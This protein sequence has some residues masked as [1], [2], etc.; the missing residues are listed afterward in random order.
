M[1]EC[2][3]V[4]ITDKL[5]RY[6]KVKKDNNTFT[7]DSYGL[8]FYSNLNET[9]EQ[10]IAETN[11]SNIPISSEVLNE[12]YY[13]FNIFSLTNKTYAE[14]AIKTEFES[15]CTE[16]HLNSNV[17]DGK[18]IYT[19]N[20]DN[21][22]QSRI[23]YIFD[24]QTDIAERRS[25]FD[26]NKVETLVPL[27]TTLPNLITAEKNKNSMIINIDEKTTIT[28]IVNQSIYNIDIL[29]DG[30]KDVLERINE[31]ENSY[32]K[33]YEVCKN[34]TIYTM[35]TD[36]S[37]V[38]DNEYLKYI[39]P[40][41]FKIQ[42]EVQRLKE[43][44]KKIDNIYITGMGAV[45]NN[46]DLYFK[47]YFKET[48]VEIL[49]PYFLNDQANVNIKDYIEVNSAIALA[50]QG[51][52]SGIKT[53]NFLAR[54][55]KSD[56]MT[57]LTS[58]VSTLRANKKQKTKAPKTKKKLNFN[59]KFDTNMKGQ[60][61]K[62]ETILLRNVVTAI[63]V[64]IIYSIASIV[65]AKQID[66]KTLEAKEVQS[67]TSEQIAAA[68]NDDSV[69]LG[70]TAD[71][72]TYTTNLENSSSALEQRRSRKN[73]LT[74]LLNK[75]VYNIP[76]EVTLTQINNTERTEG[77]NTIQHITMQAQARRYEQLAYFK[78]KLK[79]A[80]ILDNITSTEGQKDGSYVTITI[81][82]DLK[83]Y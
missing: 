46:I 47:E 56:L 81:E 26:G 13:Y 27:P 66:N 55:W 37:N 41:L 3:G 78:A 15:Y 83:T 35:E 16:N 80:N 25:Y 7:V 76:D 44:Y 10:I 22:D 59:F 17:Y 5:I 82:G 63:M 30:M 36:Y 68:N 8:K 4:S 73:Q 50:M 54:N 23:I 72:R 34:T 28:T 62:V 38:E 33:S 39:V 70:R 53:L 21:P 1:Q 61:D 32:S 57:L 58:D 75:L 40:T 20:L 29:E 19:K 49:K 42:E 11:S 43:A 14:K 9:L 71:Y 24:S 77:T 74:I 31:K 69:I 48:K 45:I 79:N 52:G 12:K 6:A 2:L 65:I 60:L 67:Y 64:I 51:L 18:Y